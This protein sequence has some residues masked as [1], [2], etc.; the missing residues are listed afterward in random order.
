MWKLLVIMVLV[1]QTLATAIDVFDATQRH[2]PRVAINCGKVPFHI[3]LKTGAWV[4]DDENNTVCD[5]KSKEDVKGYCQKVYPHINVTNIVE[6]NEPVV[7]HNW[8]EPLQTKKCDTVKEVVP[9]RCLMNEYEADALMV[10]YGCHFDHIHD[11]DLCLSHD[12]WKIKAQH[13]CQSLQMKLKDYGILLSCGTDVFTGVEFVCCPKKTRASKKLK[14]NGKSKTTKGFDK[15]P[16]IEIDAGDRPI[17]LTAFSYAIKQFLRLTPQV[18]KGCDK[19]RYLPKQAAMEEKHRSRIAAVVEEWE[20]AEKR[21]NKLKFKDPIAAEEKMKRTL[22]VFRETIAALEQEAKQ[23]K[24]QLRY[25]HTQCISRNID[26]EKK[27]AMKT[28]VQ[29]IQEDRLVPEKILNAVQKFIKVCEHDRVH[30]LRHFEHIR[31]RDPKKADGMRTDLLQ[32]LQ[33]LNTIV[34]ASMYLLSY[35]PKVAEKFGLA[36]ASHILL[37]PRLVMPEVTKKETHHHKEIPEKLQPIQV[38]KMHN[39]TFKKNKH[40]KSAT[41]VTIESTVKTPKVDDKSSKFVE[42]DEPRKEDLRYK[43]DFD[44]DSKYVDK[45]ELIEE[46]FSSNQS[47]GFATIIGLSCGALV[48][49]L[50]ILI[51][52][53][54]RRRRNVHMGVL[55]PTEDNEDLQHLVT[56]QKKG[57]ENPTYKFFYF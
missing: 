18:S 29:A 44:D 56:M 14:A 12:Q 41:K 11:E 38:R 42:K 6:S 49:M 7:F 54:V 25:E 5:G 21:Y 32:H 28:Y 13:K 31:N 15:L 50:G 26:K 20:E 10:P 48:I 52:L 35:L 1:A 27:K 2:E 8:C 4:A 17:D 45:H 30:T 22:E 39:R 23:E 46:K 53:I 33:E 36:D 51:A 9:Y 43:E 24:E 16:E 40:S 3:D 34:N 37:K 55:V 19:T 47:A 57:F